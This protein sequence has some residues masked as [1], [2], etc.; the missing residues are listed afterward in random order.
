MEKFAYCCDCGIRYPYKPETENKGKPCNC[1]CCCDP[2][3]EESDFEELHLE[4]TEISC[5]IC[6]DT[7]EIACSPWEYARGKHSVICSL[8]C[9]I[10]YEKSFKDPLG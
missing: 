1:L 6:Y 2:E 9:E 3:N 7:M 5:M 4:I 8:E 10:E